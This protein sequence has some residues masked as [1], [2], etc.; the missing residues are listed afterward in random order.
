MDHISLRKKNTK[1]KRI[2]IVEN[3][4]HEKI[5]SFEY[6]IHEKK[7]NRIVDKKNVLHISQWIKFLRIFFLILL[8][9]FIYRWG[10][11]ISMWSI[12]IDNNEINEVHNVC[13][14]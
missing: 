6:V 2:F 14:F 4:F 7:S 5:T 12:K 13:L 3:Q 11:F 8:N 1:I 9:H 10:T